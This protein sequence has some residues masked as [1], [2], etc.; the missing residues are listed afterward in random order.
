[1]DHSYYQITEEV[2]QNISRLSPKARGDAFGI[3]GK[4]E[5][6]HCADDPIYWLD[7]T[8]HVKTK[9]HPKGMP[10]VFTKDPHILYE[11]KTCGVE[12]FG[13]KRGIHLES[14]HKIV[15]TSIRTLGEQFIELPPIRPF[16]VIEYMP[17]IAQAWLNSQFFVIEKSRDMMATWLM[18]ALFSWDAFFHKGRQHIFQSQDA[19]KTL[20]LVQRSKIIYDNTPH[21]LKQIIGPIIFGKGNTKSGELFIPRQESEIL[22]FPQG[23]DQ[24]RQFHHSG[25]FTD[26]TA[27]QVEAAASFAAIKPAIQ[28]G[29]KYVG[30]SSANRSYFELLCRDRSD[31]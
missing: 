27:F 20:E 23:A 10:Y 29:G 15:A 17:P 1:M 25:V 6:D 19:G 3:L 2:L 31:D 7:Q 28:Q 11:C 4:Y 14:S 21:F 16:T 22:G 12:L 18:V 24:I 9:S 26:E 30:I 5:F 8:Q 13:D